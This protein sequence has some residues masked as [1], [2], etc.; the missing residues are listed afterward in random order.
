[1]TVRYAIR[2]MYAQPIHGTR[3]GRWLV[4]YGTGSKP[5][6]GWADT[7]DSIDTYETVAEAKRRGWR[8][9]SVRS[10]LT[11]DT[12]QVQIVRVKP[13]RGGLPIQEIEGV[14]WPPPGAVDQLAALA[15]EEST[16]A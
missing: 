12:V 4:N 7:L 14:V 15:R 11:S 6:Y 13:G 3:Y 9:K 10:R 2:V 8:S 1:M 5:D 16:D